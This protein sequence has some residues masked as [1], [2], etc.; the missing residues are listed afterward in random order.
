M[1]SPLGPAR[2]KSKKSSCRRTSSGKS[3]SEAVAARSAPS[4]VVMMYMSPEARLGSGFSAT[5]S[6][7]DALSA[8]GLSAAVSGGVGLTVF[9]GG[10]PW[11][12]IAIASRMA[13][14]LLMLSSVIM[15]SAL[16]MPYPLIANRPGPDRTSRPLAFLSHAGNA[17]PPRAHAPVGPGRPSQTYR[18]ALSD[19]VRFPQGRNATGWPRGLCRIHFP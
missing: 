14:M 15:P 9:A 1:S 16:L 19:T 6:A 7:G 17:L 18:G 5:T 13:T 11:Q 8:V 3:R 2:L 12:P 4:G 10:C